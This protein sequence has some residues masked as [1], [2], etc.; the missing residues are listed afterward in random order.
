MEEDDELPAKEKKILFPSLRKL[1]RKR[2][3]GFGG[4]KK[5][6]GKS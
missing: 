6:D 2:D 4:R 5:K 3:A 1:A